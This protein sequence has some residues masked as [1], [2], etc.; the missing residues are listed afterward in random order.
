MKKAFTLFGLLS[1]GLVLFSGSAK[2][3]GLHFTTNPVAATTICQSADSFTYTVAAVDSSGDLAIS[4]VWQVSTNGGST[5]SSATDSA[6]YSGYMTSSLTVY[7]HG[8]T[9]LNGYMFRCQATD[10]SSGSATSTSATLDIVAPPVAGTI[11]GGSSLCIGSSAT[12]TES[13]SGGVWSS[14]NTA[15]ATV[16]SATG[17]LTAMSQGKDAVIYTVSNVCATLTAVDSVVIDTLP[18]Q[19]TISGNDSVCNGST[20]SLTESLPGGVWSSSS[21]AV[22]TVSAGVVTSVSEGFT[23]IYYTITNTFGC[24]GRASKIVRVDTSVVSLPLSGPTVTC[25]GNTITLTDPNT[26]GGS[27]WMVSNGAASVSATGDVTGISSGIDTVTL[28]FTNA[29]NSVTSTF[30]VGIDTVLAHGTLSGSSDLCSGSWI[31]LTPS[32][33]GGFWLSGNSAIAVVDGSGNVT[34]VSYGTTVI[35]YVFENACGVSAAVHTIAVSTPAAAITAA[36]DSVG[37]GATR[38][39]SN[40]AVGGSWSTGDTAIA[41]VGATTGVVTG[42]STGVTTITYTVTNFC[43]TTSAYLTINVGPLPDAG[44]ISPAIDSVCVGHTLGLTETV[45][46]GTWSSG[47][48]SLA[49]VNDAGIVTGVAQGLVNI[50]YTFTNAFGASVSVRSVYVNHTPVLVLSYPN[51]FSISGQYYPMASPAGGY[52]KQSNPSVGFMDY[53]DHIATG[54]TFY[55]GTTMYTSITYCSLV[56]IG[57]G[58][59]TV[60]YIDSNDC[61][62]ADSFFVINL[63]VSNSVVKVT[64]SANSL[65]LYPNPNNGTFS[66]NLPANTVEEAKVVITNIVG[67]VVK[68]MTVTTNSLT[69]ID[70]QDQASGTYFLSASTADNRYA[71]KFTITR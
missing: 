54:D 2:A 30:A 26:R 66:F 11:S 18:A 7:T 63:P 32:L 14:S 44:V 9:A 56:I 31:N 23:T 19:G 40:E 12:Y 68:E 37:I 57:G 34:G 22:A 61:G 65:V 15:L 36:S 48:T 52:W 69:S 27:V 64:G 10:T 67:Q 13:A 43:G 25:V 71:G 49:T 29:C 47:N 41:T 50:T 21:S 55:V 42:V 6:N 33:T 8:T 17:V 24:I 16:G 28:N 59:D 3:F 51:I 58:I 20:L 5:W 4:Y 53:N 62:R 60:H 38:T 45:A 39:L 70:L 35:S 1:L 46:G